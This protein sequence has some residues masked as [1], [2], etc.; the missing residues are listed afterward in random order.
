MIRTDDRPQVRDG[1]GAGQ[2]VGVSRP[3]LNNFVKIRAQDGARQGCHRNR[4]TDLLMS[5]MPV[6][7]IGVSSGSISKVAQIWLTIT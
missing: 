6:S 7:A 2:A 4:L 3:L 5:S 1:A